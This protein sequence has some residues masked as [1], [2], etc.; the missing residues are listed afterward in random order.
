MFSVSPLEFRFPLD[1]SQRSFSFI[2]ENQAGAPLNFQFYVAPSPDLTDST[3]GHLADWVV[4]SET[5]LTLAPGEKREVSFS[6]FPPSSL[7]DGG[8]YANLYVETLGDT[9][10]VAPEQGINLSSRISIPLYGIVTSGENHARTELRA[11]ELSP[12]FTFSD[13]Y[14]STTLKNSGN[15]DFS[16]SSS[17]SVSSLLGRE[18]Y[19]S[20]SFTDVLPTTEKTIAFNWGGTPPLGLYRLTYSLKAADLNAS[21]SRIVVVASPLSFGIFVFLILFAFLATFFRH[22]HAPKRHS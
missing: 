7:P 13:L 17:F 16:V 1:A 4:L 20:S 12:T 6:V 5:S 9:N 8:Q 15:L 11:L 21:L 3:Y 2:V 18:L 14:A 22:A 10:V 19:S